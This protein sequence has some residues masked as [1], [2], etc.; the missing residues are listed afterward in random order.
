MSSF[1]RNSYVY[2]RVRKF[3]DQAVYDF[4]TYCNDTECGVRWLQ[5]TL[6]YFFG[7]TTKH[8]G[9]QSVGGDL[10]RNRKRREW[11]WQYSKHRVGPRQL[12]G[13]E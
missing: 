13:P 4:L 3:H 11:P 7:V 8:E 10:A 12:V 1:A 5:I 6:F 9:K 2:L